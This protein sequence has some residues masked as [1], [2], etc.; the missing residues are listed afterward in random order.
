MG[1]NKDKIDWK[2]DLDTSNIKKNPNYGRKKNK[3]EIDWEYDLDTSNIKKSNSYKKVENSNYTYNKN[4]TYKP[5]KRIKIKAIVLI[6]LILIVIGGIAVGV[7]E[8]SKSIKE[9]AKPIEV[10]SA[11]ELIAAKGKD[12]ELMADLDFMFQTISPINC[13]NFNGNGHTI[14]NVII[15]ND[16]IR[17]TTSLFSSADSI[18]D[19]YLDN[20]SVSATS[21]F[22]AAILCQISCRN[23]NN[24]HIKNSKVTTSMP[25]Y[26]SGLGKSDRSVY[27]GGIY[28]GSYLGEHKEEVSSICNISNC[29]VVDSTLEI[30]KEEETSIHYTKLVIGGI[31]GTASNINNCYTSGLNIIC[32]SSGIYNDPIV[33][34]VVGYLD[35]KLENSYAINNKINVK[36]NYYSNNILNR[37]STSEATCGGLVGSVL[38]GSNIKYCYTNANQIDVSCSGDIYVGG[39][40]GT[41]NG[42]TIDNSYTYNNKMVMLGFFEENEEKVSRTLGGFIGS[43]KNDLISSSFSYNETKLVE[44]NNTKEKDSTIGGFA[45]L[46]DNSTILNVASYMNNASGINIDSFSNSVGECENCYINNYNYGNMNSCEIIDDSYFINANWMENNLNLIGLNWNFVSGKLPYLNFNND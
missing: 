10:K 3:D 8:I 15:S 34:G 16:S 21:S 41:S 6:V 23:I 24:V 30:V 37:A 11:E 22:G 25:T 20:I 46:I 5:K 28:S 32:T 17:G 7:I 18:N 2:Y 31:A 38:E 45:G 39:I 1:S 14:K 12:I 26:G 44:S 43:T 36:A 33:G 42:S 35:G 9:N 13:K 19:L 4:I 27:V 29:S 40:A